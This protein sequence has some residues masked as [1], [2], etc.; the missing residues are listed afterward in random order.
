MWTLM[1]KMANLWLAGNIYIRAQ[2]SSDST[3]R[4]GRGVTQAILG[5][6]KDGFIMSNA[7]LQE[8]K[9][10]KHSARQRGQGIDLLLEYS[11]SDFVRCQH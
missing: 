1:G 4:F 3:R 6:P 7:T 2:A 10:D 9:M 8:R 11:K 5:G